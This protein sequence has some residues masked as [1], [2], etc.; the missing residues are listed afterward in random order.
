M[1]VQKF[2]YNSQ[3]RVSAVELK[4]FLRT[5]FCGGVNRN[6]KENAFICSL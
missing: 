1:T 3:N 4:V 2:F 6:K 5:I